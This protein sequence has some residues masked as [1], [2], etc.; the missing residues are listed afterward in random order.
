MRLCLSDFLRMCIYIY[1]LFFFFLLY[2]KWFDYTRL[3]GIPFFRLP[4]FD[5]HIYI[6]IFIFL[7]HAPFVYF[8]YSIPF[9]HCRDKMPNNMVSFYACTFFRFEASCWIT[10]PNPNMNFNQ[11]IPNLFNFFIQ[12][13][14]FFSL[15]IEYLHF[16][17][18]KWI[19]VST[20]LEFYRVLINIWISRRVLFFHR[21]IVC[22]EFQA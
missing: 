18:W 2:V 8:R 16:V 7:M 1:V 14:I 20:Q 13:N 22:I 12:I 17:R 21:T 9:S 19:D 15:A 4:H 11:I 3:A 10:K 5:F 6:Y